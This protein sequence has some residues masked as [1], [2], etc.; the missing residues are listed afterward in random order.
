MRRLTLVL[1]LVAAPD[2]LRAQYSITHTYTLGGDG[3]WD[4]VVPDPAN[5]RLFIGRQNRVMVVDDRDGKLIGEVSG[6]NG[7]HGTAVA[8][9]AGHGFATS[10][11]DSSIVMFDLKTFKTLGR[12]HA[13]ED[14]DAIIYDAVSNRVFSFNGDA[15][16]STVVDPVTGKVATNIP[17][18]GKP[19]YGVSAG[20]GKVYANL[21]D[22]SEVVEI[23]ATKLTVTRRWST[24]PCK[25]PVSMAIDARN[26]RLFS[27]CRS[28]VA[29]VS[30]IT[31]GKVVATLPIG[32]GVDGAAFDPATGDAFFSCA[33]GTLTVIHQDSPDKYHVAQTVQTVTG[34]RNMGLNP[35]THR[36]YVVSAKYGPVPD[37]SRSNPRRRPP[38]L[39]GSFSIMVIEHN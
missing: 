24:A 30:D 8:A 1:F 39:P 5:H 33:D 23:D 10:G 29:A 18:G 32:A 7:A 3:G 31:T 28:G 9:K 4:Y 17:L 16:S 12:A 25:Q 19:E 22:T 11:N 34:G 37:S 20:D 2:L 13:A 38:V 14:A 6:I 15:H 35:V 26:H 21:T 27:G 36:V